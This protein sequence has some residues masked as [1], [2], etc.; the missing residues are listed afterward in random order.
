[1][2]LD[3]LLGS[4]LPTTLL[5]NSWTTR[6]RQFPTKIPSKN[7]EKK[8]WVN[9][10]IL[11]SR[12]RSAYGWVPRVIQ[13]IR[14][15]TVNLGSKWKN[16]TD[17][18]EWSFKIINTVFSTIKW[19]YIRIIN[20][21]LPRFKGLRKNPRQPIPSSLPWR[22][23]VARHWSSNQ[24]FDRHGPLSLNL[25]CSSGAARNSRESLSRDSLAKWLNYP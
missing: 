13:K 21:F 23:T 16:L 6:G 20:I 25:V 3:C 14:A 9:I 24:S 18:F 7:W 11:W 22:I 8:L 17:V 1:M 10:R 5:R 19:L 15:T 4:R 12:R 2:A